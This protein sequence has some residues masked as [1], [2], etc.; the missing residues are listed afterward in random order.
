MEVHDPTHTAMNAGAARSIYASKMQT[1][2]RFLFSLWQWQIWAV[3]L[4]FWTIYALLD[5]AG[6]FAIL[7]LRRQGYSWADVLVWN[8]AE[9]YVW[10]LLTPVI[11]A[12]TQKHGFFGKHWKRSLMVHIPAG[13]IMMVVSSWLLLAPMDYFG[14]SDILTPFRVRLSSLALQDLPR[15]FVTVAV[16]QIV[17]YYGTL[18]AREEESIKLEGKLAQAQLQTLRAQMEPHFLFNALNSIATLARKDPPSAERMTMQLAHLLRRSLD[19]RSCQK[20]PLQEELDFL[21]NYIDIQ[22]ARF[23]DRLTVHMSVDPSVLSTSVPSMILQPLV[24]NA[25]QHGIA[26]SAAPGELRITALNV[27]GCLE[28]E[29]AD[30]GAG[31][32]NGTS[33][34]RYGFGLGNTRT[35]LRQ[36]YGDHH[37]FRIEGAETGGCKVKLVLPKS[38]P[39]GLPS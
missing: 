10:V 8:F 17:L 24:E 36:I 35:R 28:I 14:W 12:I 22:Q 4:A 30:N 1:A 16:A 26:N 34:E 38:G 25:I 39:P 2:N 6:S 31:L 7:A 18:R 29:V 11:C 21:Q 3:S 23:H 15:Y 5:S 20:I 37:Q 13:I 9:A 19:T 32:I 33:P 27:N